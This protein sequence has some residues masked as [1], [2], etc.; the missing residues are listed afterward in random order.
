MLAFVEVKNMSGHARKRVSKVVK[1]H[2]R[3]NKDESEGQDAPDWA[4]HTGDGPVD[5]L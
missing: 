3:R 4:V 2:S 5:D 1:R